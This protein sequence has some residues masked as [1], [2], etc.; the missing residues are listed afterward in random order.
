MKQEVAIGGRRWT[1]A[2][3]PGTPKEWPKEL[4]LK[5]TSNSPSSLA[6]NEA[7][8]SASSA[9]RFLPLALTNF[10]FNW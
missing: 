2:R 3:P 10:C 5:R 1:E 6:K 7:S 4:Y 9:L 8:N